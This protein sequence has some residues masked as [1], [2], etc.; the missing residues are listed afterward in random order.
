MIALA[1]TAARM[2]EALDWAPPW[3]VSLAVLALAA[4]L[5]L[6][7]HLILVLLVR[8]MTHSRETVWRPFLLRSSAPTRAALVICALGLAAPLAALSPGQVSALRHVLLIG[9]IVVVGWTSLIALD[10]AA[11]IY[12]RAFHLEQGDTPNARKHLT[13]VRILQRAMA[14][15][16]VLL[17][18]AMALMTISGV[19]QWGVSLLAAGGA[20]SIIVGLA[21][22]PVLSS[23]IAGIQLAMTQPIRIGDE[24][25]VEGENGAI[26]EIR[27]TY[28]IIRTWDLRR[29]IVP[30]TY[31]NQ[32]PF[33]N[34]TRESPAL[35]GS[36]MLYVDFH[37]PVAA[38]REHLEA[39]VRGDPRWDGQTLDL[40]VTDVREQSV[41]LRCLMSARNSGDIWGL[42]CAV[43]EQMIGFLQARMPW[44]LPRSRHELEDRRGAEATETEAADDP[45]RGRLG[46]RRAQ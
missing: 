22:Q 2:R 37:T 23:L 20:A 15:L 12:S 3:M 7:A 42:R 45:Q 36:V 39:L 29:L 18:A 9:F 44:A 31:F 28:V 5:A 16:I 32:K 46:P 14:T 6:L 13:Q 41:E 4:G 34:W 21:L 11:T 24:V 40:S 43:R 8:R 30:L 25:V 10:L 17:T 35:I 33:Q 38:L 19:R 1:R 27:S 26:E